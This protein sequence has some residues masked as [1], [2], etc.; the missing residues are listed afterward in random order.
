[1]HGAAPG[2]IV[3]RC[4]AGLAMVG[5]GVAAGCALVSRAPERPP[6]VVWR[7]MEAA[8]CAQGAVSLP[9]GWR[10]AAAE[11]TVAAWRAESAT[12]FL[13]AQA[14]VDGDGIRDVARLAVRSDGSGFGLFIFVCRRQGAA[15][16]F[17]VR[18]QGGLETLD[19]YGVER[20]ER[21]VYR[22]A[23]DRRPARCGPNEAAAVTVVDEAFSYFDE[24]G[25]SGL[26]VWDAETQGLRW[27]PVRD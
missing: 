24:E 12:R 15:A 2:G 6:E 10:E 4:V 8:R 1:M 25:G 18:E 23:C 13:T 14:D 3:R 5:W 20:A 17:L 22:A 21:G 19:R 9:L 26:F 11:E 27:V 7:S 16:A